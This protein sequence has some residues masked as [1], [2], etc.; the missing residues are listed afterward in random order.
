M[1]REQEACYSV[2]KAWLQ[3]LFPGKVTVDPDKPEFSTTF[4][5]GVLVR[6]RID[7]WENPAG[8]SDAVIRN[9]A[10]LVRSITIN[11]LLTR[12]MAQQNG[13]SLFGSLGLNSNEDVF[14]GH[15]IIGSTCDRIELQTS[16]MAV[17]TNAAEHHRAIIEM[18]GESALGQ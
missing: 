12:Y 13:L 8:E 4:P 17:A 11:L 2:V 18:G 16:V 15:S 3:L 9:R 7:A 6:T 10:L 1:T 14:F 5:S